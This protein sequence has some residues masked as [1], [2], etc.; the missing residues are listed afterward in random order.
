MRGSLGL[1]AYRA[2]SARGA[3]PMYKPSGLRPN[4]ELLWIHAAEAGSGRAISDLGRQT[5]RLRDG[6]RVLLTLG[7]SVA[8][9]RVPAAPGITIEA[10]PQDHP[11]TISAFLDHWRPDT[12]LWIWGGLRPNTIL[13]AQERKIPMILADAGK[14]GFDGR[15]DR[16]LPE[17]PRRLLR[18]FDAWLARSEAAQLRLA[19]LGCPLDAIERVPPLLPVGQTLPASTA[20][21]D[22][23]RT[24][25]GGR[26]CWFARAVRLSE[27]PTVLTAHRAALRQAHRLLLV[28]E[29]DPDADVEAFRARIE[30]EEMRYVSW[31]EGSLPT[32]ECGILL[33]DMPDEAGLWFRVSSV[34]FLGSSLEVGCSGTDPYEAA[35]HGSAVLYGPHVS[36]YLRSYSRL[37]AA[38]AA[39]IVSDADSLGFALQ[40]LV[41]PDQAATMALAGWDVITQGAAAT[42]RVIALVEDALDNRKAGKG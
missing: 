34:S 33:A 28:L 27:L 12:G 40:R 11:R 5:M 23:V 18:C 6:L 9:E 21:V 26:P 24:E 36:A 14:D 8:A 38:G 16:W 35:A 17:V 2:L 7:E 32:A 42:D 4:G 22:E 37:A 30:A 19:Q 10:L 15:R 31:S 29:P 25:L 13:G 20:E 3:A 39:R 41:A 1:A